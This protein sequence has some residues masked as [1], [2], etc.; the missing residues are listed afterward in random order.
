LLFIITV[1]GL[2]G[3]SSSKDSISYNDSNLIAKYYKR[4]KLESNKVLTFSKRHEISKI[5]A[6]KRK[7]YY[8]VYYLDIKDPSPPIA[9][10]EKY[11][12]HKIAKRWIYNRSGLIYRLD[13]FKNGKL[14]VYYLYYYDKDNSSDLVK[15]EKYDN[16]RRLRQV[17]K[18]MFGEKEEVDYY[19]TSGKKTKTD[20]YAGAE[21]D[22]TR[23]YDKEGKV[24]REEGKYD[25]GKYPYSLRYVYD[26][27]NI[28]IKIEDY[29][30][31]KLNSIYYYNKDGKTVKE[32]HYQN[33]KLQKTVKYDS[34]GSVVQ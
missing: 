14:I 20:L 3:C 22:M 16:K 31:N 23:Y 4:Y 7:L 32:E 28:L 8:K 15:R 5:K 25:N 34:K 18:Y 19:D 21:V 26:G 27:N 6:M 24:I 33:G 17:V 13:D 9:K 30:R 11:V 1:I 10:I 12:K 2:S 29:R